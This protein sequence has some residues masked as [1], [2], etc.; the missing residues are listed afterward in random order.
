MLFRPFIT[1]MNRR[2]PSLPPFASALRRLLRC[3]AITGFIAF[4]PAFAQVAVAPTISTQ[5]QPLAAPK[6]SVAALTV[7]G[8]GSPAP[9]YLWF[10][11]GVIVP[12][13]SAPTLVFARLQPFDA[14]TYTVALTNAAGTTTS[15]AAT[16][17]VTAD[18]A[19][20]STARWWNEALLDAIRLDTP[21]PPVHARNLFHLSAAFWDAFHAYERDG[22]AARHEVFHRESVNNLPATEPARLAAQREAMSFAAYTVLRA[23]FA[24]GPGAAATTAGL[25]WLMQRHGFSADPDATDNLSASPAAVGLR[26]GQK[27]LALQL[28]DGANEAGNY[29][30]ATGYTPANPPLV[31]RYTGI[32]ADVN[33]DRW[34]PLDLLNT[35]TQNGLVLGA[36]VQPFVG[37]N[38]KN[39]RTFA[40]ART[41]DG[42]LADDP[43]PPPRLA[44]PDAA[45]R[46]ALV[47]QAV[48]VLAFSSQ[49]TA[50]D[51]ATVDISPGKIFNNP[52]GT[53]SGRGHAVNPVTG[54][55]Y[56]PNLVN[57][58][59][60]A[61]VLTEYWA[62]GPASETPP[63][64]WNL[65]F[66]QISD[67]PL[68]THLFLGTGAPLSRLEWDV[69]GYLAL[70]AALHD[71]ACAAWTLKWRYDSARPIT[72][73]RALAGR[74]QSSDPALPRYHVE[75]LPL[76]PGQ[77]E[78]IT[79]ASSAPGQR[80]EF[81]ARFVGQIAVRAWLGTPPSATQT[82]GVGWLL[83]ED[84]VPYQR[85]TFVTPAF[86]GYVSGHSTFSRAAA[87]VLTRLTGSKFFPGGLSTTT[88]AAGRTLH[89]EAGPAATVSLQAATYYDAAD[90]AGL[91]RLY[92]GIHIAA[93]DLTGR[94]LGAKIGADA[95][96]RFLAL[97][98][99]SSLATLPAPGVSTAA[100]PAIVRAP[101]AI[102]TFAGRTAQLSVEVAGP[103]PMTYQWLRAGTAVGNAR[104]LELT[105]L[106]AADAGDYRVTITNALGTTTSAPVALVLGGPPVLASLSIRAPAGP[107]ERALIAGFTVRGP[108]G[109]SVTPKS[110]LVRGLGPALTAFG[111]P[112]ALPAPAL[113]LADSAGRTLAQNTRW[114]AAATPASLSARV[115]AFPLA[116]GSADSALHA[117]LTPGSYTA[118]VTDIAGRSGP[119]L[120]E[121]TETDATTTRLANLSARAHLGPGTE[122]GIAG[123]VVRGERPARYL[124][125]GIGPALAPFGITNPLAAPVLTLTTSDGTAL[126]TNTRW[127]TASNPAE[128]ALAATQTGAFPLPAAS[129]DSALLITLAPGTYTAHLTG[130][131]ATSGLALLEIYEVP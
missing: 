117:A 83:G 82:A 58:G 77:I 38:A 20:K 108:N 66:N 123:F 8:T 26:I 64:H 113:T 5:P 32:G 121:L 96:A 61:R 30:N 52:I 14:G 17:N 48:E 1:S 105:N 3:W 27:I 70:N 37:A 115:G 111:V 31:V 131:A 49:L 94:R 76:I 34:Q 74:G 59:D 16:L 55:P 95:F 104:T 25:R 56:A 128:I 63:G 46:A 97:H 45:T 126:A 100:A 36:S 7:V 101:A 9:T 65:V 47:A 2:A 22:W 85:E 53:Y 33:P 92:G 103:G 98:G 91:S 71:A 119:A 28:D 4:A 109:G 18:L 112:G 41:A 11:D 124:I 89:V 57:R 80:H 69:T 99:S 42:F 35:V 24:R 68:A 73:I 122:L 81:L 67:H 84:W 72:L 75:G 40:L 86:P 50:A 54:L 106:S 44:A 12:G 13:Q 129:T 110:V 62:D 43:G 78:L 88:F 93:D 60:Y 6:D 127:S 107:G 87:E 29:A 118:V 21:N 51:T 125:R 114:D 130:A 39:T 19:A 120:I 15:L 23:R 90:Q 79:A 102:T 10:K 116:A